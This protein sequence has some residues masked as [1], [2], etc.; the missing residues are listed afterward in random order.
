MK[1]T[2]GYFY[3]DLLNLYGDNGN[4]EILM[5]RC[6]KRDIDFEIVEIGAETRVDPS[7]LKKLNI[8]F[9]GGGP[10]SAQKVL[11]EDLTANKASFLRDYI[12]N[13]G[14]GLYI[15]GAYQLLGKYYKAA[16]GTIL[17]GLGILNLYTRHFG[18][19]KNRCIGNTV[20]K[21]NTKISKDP[22]FKS[23]CGRFSDLITGF[24]N[25][26]GRTYLGKKL[27]PLGFIE[28]GNGNNSEDGAEGVLYKNS[29]GTYFHGPFLARNP[30]I[31]DYIIA[32]SLNLD[33]IEPLNDDLVYSAYTASLKLK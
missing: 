10:D 7:L 18:D 23:V 1:L 21:L 4:I 33:T 13:E 30:H 5:Y 27:E 31:A 3:K 8:V 15:C 32:K 24:E 25:H 9:M 19:Q 12:E 26:G 22:Y 28:K 16:D 14:I 2:V 17:K 29:I 6:K 11:Y 20:A